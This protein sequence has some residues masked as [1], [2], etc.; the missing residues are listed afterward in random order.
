MNFST[1]FSPVPRGSRAGQLAGRPTLLAL[2]ALFFALVPAFRAA[3]SHIRAGDIQARSDPAILLRYHFTL[4]LYLNRDAMVDQPRATLCFGDG[5]FGEASAVIIDRPNRC[6]NVSE[7]TYE[8]DHVFPGP[9]RYTISFR[10]DNRVANIRNLDASSDL[11]FFIATKILIDAAT[12]PN[13]SP[14]FGQ[15]PLQQGVQFQRFEHAPAATDSSAEGDSIV[16]QLEGVRPQQ[17]VLGSA[18]CRAGTD[19]LS[20]RPLDQFS[21]APGIFQMDPQTGLLVWDAPSEAGEY[22]IAYLVHEWRDLGQGISREVST[23]RRDM[24]ITI[25]AS[26]NRPPVLQIPVDTCV[27]A[28]TSITKL[29]S[30]TDP[31]NN[32]IRLTGAGGP[33][34]NTPAPTLTTVSTR[35]RVVRF[36]WTPDCRSV[37]RQP[38]LA[39]FTASDTAR[40]CEFPELATVRVWRIRVVGPPPLNLRA[41]EPSLR[42]IQLRWDAYECRGAADSI[43]I[44]R[45]EDS[46]SFIP[47][48][49]ETGIP[50]RLGYEYVGSVAAGE[51]TFLDRNRGR[52]F[53]RGTTY[54]YRIYATWPLPGGGESIASNEAC[55]TIPGLLPLLTNAT[56]DVTDSVNGQVTVKWTK[57]DAGPQPATFANY[58]RLSRATADAPTDFTPVLDR[59]PLTDTTHV[60]RGLDTDRLQYVYQLEFVNEDPSPGGPL[61]VIDTVAP[62]STVRLAGTRTGARIDLTWAYTVPWDNTTRLHYIYRR[63]AGTYTLIDSVQAAASGGAYTDAFTFGGLT[64]GQESPNCYRIRT[65]GTYVVG[66]RQPAPTENFSQEECVKNQPCPPVLA[67]LAPDCAAE[68]T[69]CPAAYQNELSW[70]PATAPECST[71]LV[72]WRVYFRPTPDGKPQLLATVPIGQLTYAHGPLLS[73]IGCYFVTAIDGEGTESAAS[74]LVCQDNCE[75]FTLPN[76]ITPNGDSRNDTFEPICA[77]PLRRV[78][79]TVYN[80]WGVQVY[81]ADQNPRIQW[82]GTATNAQRLSDGTYFYRAEVEF[83]RL[84]PTT[85][86]YKGWVL[87]TGSQES[88]GGGR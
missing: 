82:G 4:K 5:T 76:V 32:P 26:T 12:G 37:T 86:F 62:A 79:F 38:Y 18:V 36:T 54:C 22:N 42:Q 6:L 75:L 47:G 3:A 56:V 49:C 9:G 20:Y 77:S 29:I 52:L 46:A 16:Y 84:Q 59:I 64:I 31:D 70:T 63:I 55:A 35:P 71:D 8:F 19:I 45:R 21:I 10:E 51:T 27:V 57:G 61:T 24:Q 78:R 73:R 33:F 65:R 39:T 44:Y 74:N 48:P 30:A 11:S 7:N 43:R 13:S 17:G 67:I 58:Y 15:F 80:R 87:I 83:D 72:S 23:T 1:A 66:T 85:R 14:I 69:T 81:D 25:L 2:L 88:A 50:R 53:K 40:N 28:N 68:A 41:S 60:D 34:L